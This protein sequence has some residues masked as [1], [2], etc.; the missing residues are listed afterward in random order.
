[1]RKK[2]GPPKGPKKDLLCFRLLPSVIA[3][4]KAAAEK[5]RLKLNVLGEAALLAY[6]KELD[7]DNPRGA[8]R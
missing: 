2:S 8:Y 3:T 1:M 5:H 7:K 6:V 4:V